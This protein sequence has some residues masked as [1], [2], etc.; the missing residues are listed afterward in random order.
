[1]TKMSRHKNASMVGI[2]MILKNGSNYDSEVVVI[3]TRNN[4][5]NYDSKMGVTMN[6]EL[7]TANVTYRDVR[8]I[9]L[10]PL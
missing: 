10:D 7:R 5:S 1:M 3:M 8:A 9:H 4:G 2:I 6:D